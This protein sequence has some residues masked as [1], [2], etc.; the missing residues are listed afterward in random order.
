MRHK[1]HKYKLTMAR[2][3]RTATMKNLSAELID[4]KKIKTTITKCKALKIYVEKLVTIAKVDSL[5]N[6]RLI[7][8]KINN[9]KAVSTLFKEVAPKFASRPGGYTR[10][11]RLPDSR[12]GDGST[13]A[14][15]A[16]V[17]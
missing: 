1:K 3:Q 17:D 5:A 14:Y 12:T 10:I 13:M 4:H 15:I 11:V 7:Y 6:R 2:S 8:S 9:R 16:F